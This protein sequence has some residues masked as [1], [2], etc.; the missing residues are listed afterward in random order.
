[1]ALISI[2]CTF[3]GIQVS[4]SVQAAAQHEH[5]PRW[6][7]WTD[8]VFLILFAIEISARM[9]LDGPNFFTGSNRWWNCFDCLCTFT[10][11]LDVAMQWV[12]LS[13]VRALKILRVFRLT[14]MLGAVRCIRA[15]RMMVASI[16][17]SLISLMWAFVLLAFLLYL[18]AIFIMQGMESYIYSL[19]ADPRADLT[20]LLTYYG[21]VDKSMLSLFMSITGGKDW[22][23][24]L[25]PLAEITWW[26]VAFFVLYVTFVL[27]GVMNVLTAIFVESAGQIAQ[28]D[29]ELVIQEEISQQQSVIDELRRL[30]KGCDED[31]SGTIT[32]QELETLLNKK[33]ITA[34]LHHLGI[35][36]S[37]AKGLFQLLDLDDVKAVD[38]DEL[39]SGIMRMK[40]GATGL[41]LATVMFENKKVYM[42]LNAFMHFVEDRFQEVGQ[43][44]GAPTAETKKLR[45]LRTYVQHERSKNR[46]GESVFYSSHE[47]ID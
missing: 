43:Q 35:D 6:C 4:V 16:V 37:E 21:R 14:R 3:I 38:I 15:L 8:V 27:F 33:E 36:I 19:T 45:T 40:G 32:D 1:M 2:N 7:W 10:S 25:S 42:R 26:Y 46:G 18:F 5:P 9:L 12:D 39:V 22:A 41:D 24:T 13:Y 47:D 30:L 20:T 34:Y 28:I 11:L 44:L 23:D 17:C 29:K 31:Q